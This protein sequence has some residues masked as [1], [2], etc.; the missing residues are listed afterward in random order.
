MAD[1]WKASSNDR[2]PP[3]SS[4]ASRSLEFPTILMHRLAAHFRSN[5]NR[6][7]P[8][9]QAKETQSKIG[10]SPGGASRGYTTIGF[11][12]LLDLAAVGL[13][14][15]LARL[16]LSVQRCELSISKSGHSSARQFASRFSARCL[17]EILGGF[18]IELRRRRKG[19]WVGGY[20]VLGYDVAP[21]GGRLVVNEPEAERVRNIFALFEKYQ[22]TLQTLTEIERRG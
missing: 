2:H 22:S 8:T 13:L 18:E 7:P 3:F 21:G 10:Q 19:K 9:M 15:N 5:G 17:A 20:P 11:P 1:R 12:K 14:R 4:P 16:E 6:A